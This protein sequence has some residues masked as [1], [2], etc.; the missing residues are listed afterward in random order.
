VDRSLTVWD[1]L[2]AYGLEKCGPFR[3]DHEPRLARC[4]C[5]DRACRHVNT[6]LH[7]SNPKNRPYQLDYFL[8]T[9]SLRER[10][11]RCWA[12][13]ARPG[14]PTATTVRSSPPSTCE[15]PPPDHRHHA[16]DRGAAW[17][18]LAPDDHLHINQSRTSG[19]D[20]VCADRPVQMPWKKSGQ[21]SACNRN[22]G[23]LRAGCRPTRVTER[24]STPGAMPRRSPIPYGRELSCSLGRVRADPPV[25]ECWVITRS[26]RSAGGP[27]GRRVVIAAVGRGASSLRRGVVCVPVRWW[28]GAATRR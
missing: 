18:V 20:A 7:G 4:P 24:N 11:R 12:D 5:P 19:N 2:A 13:P 23:Y 25:L 6:Y 10:L 22:G 21:R 16:G 15:R 26:R 8:A 1:R 9:P 3:P 17:L 27:P 14:W 28:C